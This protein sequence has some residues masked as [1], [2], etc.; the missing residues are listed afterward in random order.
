VGVEDSFLAL[1]FDVSIALFGASYES[2]QM[3]KAVDEAKAEAESS[4]AVEAEDL[5]MGMFAIG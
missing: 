4:D 5:P 3:K 1:D 2:E